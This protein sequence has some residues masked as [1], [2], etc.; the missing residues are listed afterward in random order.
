MPIVHA[1]YQT[2]ADG[3]GRLPHHVAAGRWVCRDGSPG[4]LPPVGLDAAGGERVVFKHDYDAFSA[5]GLE[6]ALRELGADPLWI[7]GVHAHACVRDTA[8]SA[9][10]RGL[11]VCVIADAIAS[12]DPIHA[13]ATRGFLE[14]RGIAYVDAVAALGQL[15]GP[16][17]PPPAVAL[18]TAATVHEACAAVARAQ[19]AWARLATGERVAVLSRW[20]AA[21]RDRA[22]ELAAL[23]AREIGKPVGE[24]LGEARRAADTLDVLAR[25]VE[26]DAEVVCAPGIRARRR[27]VGVVAAITPWNNPV[28]IP[29]AKLG[30]ALA[31]G[32][33]AV[34]KP[35]P[36]CP[37]TSLA[38]Y[39][40]LPP[41]CVA[42][43]NGADEAVQ[44]I[45]ADPHV[46]A[47]SFTG[48]T[49]AGKLVAA[50]SARRAKPIQAELG[51]NNAVVVTTARDI[52][53]TADAIVHS[54]FDFAGQGCTATR[55]VVVLASI[56]DE[57]VA[58]ILEAMRTLVIGAPD[59]PAT[60]V[61]PV[62][63]RRSQRRVQMLLDQARAEGA[64]VTAV[65]LPAALDPRGHWLAPTLV[66]NA[67]PDSAIV[68]EETFAPVLVVQVAADLDA[69]IALCNGVTQGL[70]ASLYADDPAVQAAF[71]DGAQAGVLKLGI[72]TRGVHLEAPFVGWKD[73][74][75]GPPEHGRWDADFY[76]RWQA[77]Y[78][79]T[80]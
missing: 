66:Q 68:Q 53:S 1:R 43:V 18:D 80:S 27:P 41:T 23:M 31:Y 67:A 24:G 26:A 47:V 16:S 10:R 44:Q 6:P 73:S 71:L 17:A 79:S 50:A 63:S 28:A 14:D 40:A 55:R 9:W 46:T 64:V 74:G 13:D 30:A 33:G 15:D 7:A 4:A 5:P 76:T 38:V 21:L 11:R 48:S 8:L 12:Y 32:N 70:V 52:T 34:W 54:A 56:A 69:A 20:A 72:P 59:D 37:R 3:T 36:E 75:L 65:D 19:P 62:I 39:E 61:G 58:A 51:G 57:V 49:R 60:H 42:L 22:P 2:T 35:A 77:V 25:H 45:V 78:G 29:I